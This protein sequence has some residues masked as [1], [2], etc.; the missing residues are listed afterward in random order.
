[1][2]AHAFRTFDPHATPLVDTETQRNHSNL[3]STLEVKTTYNAFR[4]VRFTHVSFTACFD[5]IVLSGH[6]SKIP[7][8]LFTILSPCE[9]SFNVGQYDWL[10]ASAYS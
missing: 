1:M 5:C 6:T 3:R 2:P 9:L 8:A 4:L 7:G 10:S